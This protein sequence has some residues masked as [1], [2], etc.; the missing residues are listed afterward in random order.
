MV[1]FSLDGW[2]ALS[3]NNFFPLINIHKLKPSS[4]IMT[5]EILVIKGPVTNKFPILSAADT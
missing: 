5:R 3:L 1:T 2:L 4:S